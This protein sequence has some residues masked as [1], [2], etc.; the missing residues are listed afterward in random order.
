MFPN[1]EIGGKK[2]ELKDNIYEN[3]LDSNYVE[4]ENFMYV[5]TKLMLQ[6]RYIEELQFFMESKH[7]TIMKHMDCGNIVKFLV[8]AKTLY[9]GQPQITY[10]VVVISISRCFGGG[11][12]LNWK[13][14]ATYEPLKDESYDTY[15]EAYEQL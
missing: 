7:Y 10:H 15:E 2:M 11:T 3:V 5:R 1:T 12:K 13:N 14:L 4:P 8:K 6:Q 9:K